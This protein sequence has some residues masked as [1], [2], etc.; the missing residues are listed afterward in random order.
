MGPMERRTTRRLGVAT[1]AAIAA[2]PVGV[3]TEAAE[4]APR[5]T[6]SERAAAAT[7]ALRKVRAPYRW[8]GTG[9]SAFDCS[10]LIGWA[11]ER[12]GHRLG[13]RTSQQMRSLGVRVRRA[14]LRRGDLVYTW[15]RGF[16]HVG[17]YVGGGR[18]VHAPGRGRRVQVAPVPGGGGFIA[19]VRP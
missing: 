9:P 3:G 19:A 15:D 17:I 14:S 6:P 2:L 8:G 1:L 12:A 4:A 11:Y 13:V 10:G 5:A 18:Y 7:N 16:G